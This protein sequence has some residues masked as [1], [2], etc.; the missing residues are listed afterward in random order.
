[1]ATWTS[2]NEQSLWISALQNRLTINAMM[3]D[4]K[5]NRNSMFVLIDRIAECYFNMQDGA[6]SA[7]F[8]P[9]Y[10]PQDH[11]QWPE[12][13]GWLVTIGEMKEVQ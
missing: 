12:L 6:Q 2:T 10:N 5:A 8:R 7:S 3:T 4:R 13:L 1:M 9:V 11:S